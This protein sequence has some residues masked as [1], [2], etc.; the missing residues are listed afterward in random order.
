MRNFTDEY[1]LMVEILNE[2]TENH[3]ALDK[4]RKSQDKRDLFTARDHEN[5][6]RR[7]MIEL[8]QK[9]NPESFDNEQAA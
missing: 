7:K 4:Y 2:V 6:V 5:I 3:A 9:Q 1:N 8:Y